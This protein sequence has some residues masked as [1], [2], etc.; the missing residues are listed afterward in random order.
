M[1]EEETEND[2]KYSNNIPFN[3]YSAALFAS[4]LRGRVAWLGN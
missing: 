1:D 2:I 3:S 4:L